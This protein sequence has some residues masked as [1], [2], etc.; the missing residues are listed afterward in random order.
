MKLSG[1]RGIGTVRILGIVPASPGTALDPTRIRAIVVDAAAGTRRAAGALLRWTRR[2]VARGII[3][4]VVG[5]HPSPSLSFLF[6]H[7]GDRPRRKVIQQ[8]VD[9]GEALGDGV[10]LQRRVAKDVDVAHGDVMLRERSWPHA[11]RKVPLS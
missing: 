8:R 1:A 10:L 4:T 5:R 2:R 6:R 11:G 7:Q 3:A 9:H